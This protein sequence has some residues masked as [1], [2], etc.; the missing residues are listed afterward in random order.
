MELYNS[1]FSDCEEMTGIEED[2]M[3][4]LQYIDDYAFANSGLSGSFVVS[5]AV[6]SLGMGAFSGC[7][8]L[9]SVTII[10]NEDLTSIGDGTF[11]GCT[12]LTEVLFGEDCAVE[13]IGNIAFAETGLTRLDLPEG[14]NTIWC[15]VFYGS[16]KLSEVTLSNP[17][18][19]G[20]VMFGLFDPYLFGEDMAE[21]FHIYLTGK[22][23]GKMHEYIE[24][25]K[26]PL[27][28]YDASM[29]MTEEEEA[30]GRS[31]AAEILKVR[32][33]T[34]SDAERPAA[35]G[36]DADK[37]VSTGSNADRRGLLDLGWFQ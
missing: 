21:D 35:T 11:S 18:P 36:S 29:D 26:Y 17:N 13:E 34:G 14:I 33:A 22:A 9:Q 32:P 7:E 30:E 3:S 12:A 20:L 16:R 5:E 27:M 19:P 15:N 28:G 31:I 24:A 1:V 2:S 37:I 10:G 25:W 6:S 4:E 8:G 23:A